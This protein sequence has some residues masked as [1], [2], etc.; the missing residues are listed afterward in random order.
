MP[1]ATV[2]RM[3]ELAV[4]LALE[5]GEI[6]RSADRVDATRK[7][8]DSL[9]TETDRT[10]QAHILAAVAKEFPDHAAIAEEEILAPEAHADPAPARFTWVIDP[11]DGTRNFVAGVPC[12]ATA[13]AVLDGG[14][15]VV[16]VVAEHNVGHLY[17]ASLGHGAT[18]NGRTLRCGEPAPNSDWLLGI[19]STK[20][21]LSVAIIRHW[22]TL[23]GFVNRN[24]GSTAVHLGMV[25]A[26]SLTAAFCKRL[27]IWD[28]AAGMLLVTEAG[29]MVTDPYGDPLVP[30]DL[31]AEPNRDIPF[32]AAPPGVHE[33][34][35]RTIR[36][37]L[38]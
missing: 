22:A 23:K 37:A 20:D 15:P 19:P 5:A 4:R 12:F 10:M 3:L 18:L 9:V 21:D 34:L 11:L 26:G 35:L 6:A 32:L 31:S 38:A 33:H 28:L 7:S 1:D 30:F 16:G 2:D 25:A 27:K 14:H 17:A 29:G 13:I 8:D 24:F 36:K